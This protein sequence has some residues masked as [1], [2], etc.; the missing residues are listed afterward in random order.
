MGPDICT[1]MVAEDA[2]RGISASGKRRLTTCTG[3][4]GIAAL[5]MG[6]AL[7]TGTDID[8]Q[9]IT[10]AHENMLLS[11]QKKERDREHVAEWFRIFLRLQRCLNGSRR[12]TRS[13]ISEDVP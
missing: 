12:T 11:A 1:D 6:A 3:V 13:S 7:F 2:I 8:P 9:A 5:K 4:L 10:T